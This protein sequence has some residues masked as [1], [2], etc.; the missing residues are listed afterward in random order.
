MADDE[1]ALSHKVNPLDVPERMIDYKFI[2]QKSHKLHPEWNC[3]KSI[4][5]IIY[6][7]CNIV[8]YSKT[9][10][11][12]YT[13]MLYVTDTTTLGLW[14]MMQL[15]EE[16]YK[17]LFITSLSQQGLSGGSLLYGEGRQRKIQVGFLPYGRIIPYCIFP[18]LI[19]HLLCIF[20]QRFVSRFYQTVQDMLLLSK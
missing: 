2:L 8:T 15:V 19:N 7:S 12:N 11:T 4:T 18:L 10:P 13:H 5:L 17:H 1:S 3:K 9:T 16:T 20:K 6:L 14:A